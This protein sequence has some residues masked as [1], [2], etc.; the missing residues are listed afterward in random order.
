MLKR[1]AAMRN[2]LLALP[3]P[4][5][6]SGLAT[7]GWIWHWNAYTNLSLTLGAVALWATYITAW[8]H[9]GT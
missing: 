4:G 7:S 5:L 8:R 9:R 6:V 1:D 2:R 3:I